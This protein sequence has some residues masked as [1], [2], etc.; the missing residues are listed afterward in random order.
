MKQRHLY[1]FLFSLLMFALLCPPAISATPLVSPSEA[2]EKPV[3]II[4][5][6]HGGVDAGTTAGIRHEKTYNLIISEY[7]RDLLTEHGGFEVY[8]TREDDETYL[9]FLPRALYI[10]EHHGDFLLSIHCNSSTVSYANGVSAIT[11]AI[12]PYSA[13]DLGETILAGISEKTGLKNKGVETREDTGDELGVYYWNAEKNWDMPG[14]SYLKTVSDYFSMNTWSS[15]FGIPSLIVEHGY[16]SNAHDREIIDNDENLKKIAEAEAAALIDYY[17]GH[18][19][20][21]TEEK[22]TD[23]PSNCSMDGTQSYHCTV[24]GIKKDTES[25][26]AAPDAHFFRQSASKLATCEEEGFIEYVCQISYNLNDKGLPTTVHTHKEILPKKDHAYE[27]TEANLPTCTQ[28]GIT[29]FYCSICGD[30]YSEEIP[31]TG[32][33]PDANSICTVCGINTESGEIP[34]TDTSAHESAGPDA[35]SHIFT[36]QSHVAPSCETEGKT[37]SVCSLCGEEMIEEAAAL[38]HDLIVSLDT[39]AVCEKDG[40]YRARCIR[41]GKEIADTRPAPGHTYAEESEQNG[42]ITKRCSLCGVTTTEQIAP[43][44]STQLF[45]S[46]L[47]IT[48][49]A[50]ILFQ[51]VFLV[52]MGLH[53]R[54][55]NKPFGKANNYT[56]EENDTDI[57]L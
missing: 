25:L 50:I 4:D 34:T 16:L 8:L 49:C 3:I 20:V 56:I 21:Y 45:R 27:K 47:F 2:V 36:E 53:R 32:H 46:P 24:C 28:K 44:E 52:V 48:V 55:V 12:P 13:F 41:C 39:P 5:P 7:L 42:V 40:Y 19:H 37:V 15:K 23:F 17:Y 6:G 30:T 38:G 14:G 54:K 51:A 10:P 29:S 9:K 26:P 11:S 35:C 43:K 22:V 18:T 57:D 33:T 31:Q 1:L